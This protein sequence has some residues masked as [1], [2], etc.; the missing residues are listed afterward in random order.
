V[1][2]GVCGGV[3]RWPSPSVT[4]GQIYRGTI[5]LMALQLV[6]AVIVFALPWLATWLPKLAYAPAR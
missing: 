4:L 3:P 5:P 2:A 6:G 1:R